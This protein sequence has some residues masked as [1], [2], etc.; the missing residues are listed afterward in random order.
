MYHPERD[1][2]RSS[3]KSRGKRPKNGVIAIGLKWGFR[4]T[5]F[6]GVFR[7]DFSGGDNFLHSIEKVSK[8]PLKTLNRGF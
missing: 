2:L 5:H 6:K 3:I 1:N 7:E 8:T 4:K